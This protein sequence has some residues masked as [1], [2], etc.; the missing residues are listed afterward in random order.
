[1]RRGHRAY[2]GAIV[3]AALIGFTWRAVPERVAVAQAP[4]GL[5]PP[6]F[7]V[8]PKWPKP[9]PNHWIVG[10]VAGVAVDSNDHVWIVH[11]PSSVSTWERGA[12]LHP[13]TPDRVGHILQNDL[14][15]PVI[16]ECCVPAP[17][18]LEFDQAGNLLR[19][20]G[21]PG[22]GYEW[23]KSEHGIFVDYRDHVWLGSAGSGTG[24]AV[25]D[26][27]QM[28]AQVLKFTTDGRFL[29]QIGRY[30]KGRGSNDREN[31]GRP[32]NAKVDP[33]TNEVFVSDGYANRRIVV[34]DADTG[35]YKRHWGAYGNRPDDDDPEIVGETVTNHRYDP[36]APPSR[37]F[38]AAHS[39][40][41]S[42]DGLVYVADR[43]NSRIQVFRR[44]GTFVKEAFVAKQ[45]LRNGSA[46]DVEF[47][48]DA[49]QQ[50]AYVL[51]GENHRVAILRRDTLQLLGTLGDGGRYPGGFISPHS[52]AV[53]SQG[54]L[55]VAETFDGKRVQRFLYKGTAQK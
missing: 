42:S 14:S 49:R 31:L 3:L 37:Q 54:N 26:R 21:G 36:D 38:R 50:F 2:L 53:D 19:H 33:D 48:K 17:P 6:I 29:L 27:A 4:A 20:W 1:M 51:D 39:V 7:E 52:V 47:S 45:T 28:D 34:F 40:A 22:A 23:P 55:Y 43:P 16:S 25:S 12:V 32:T 8:D 11:R 35:A 30:G 18:V 44:D 24:S 10:A 13:P 15:R 5:H 9:L 46:W 41:L